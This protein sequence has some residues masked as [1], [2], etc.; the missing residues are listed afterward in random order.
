MDINIIVSIIDFFKTHWQDVAA[1]WLQTVGLASVV[2]KLTP[3]LKDDDVLKSIVRFVGKYVALNH[4]V[5]TN[6]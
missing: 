3:T 1:V 4:T 2:V 5:K 6:A